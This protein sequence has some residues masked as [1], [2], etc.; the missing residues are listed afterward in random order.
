MTVG[1]YAYFIDGK[2][3]KNRVYDKFPEIEKN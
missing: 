2:I 1:V 3:F